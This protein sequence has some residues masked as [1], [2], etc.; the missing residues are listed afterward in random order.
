MPRRFIPQPLREATRGTVEQLLEVPRTVPRTVPR[1]VSLVLVWVGAT[2]LLVSC[3]LI[4]YVATV[5]PARAAVWFFF[6]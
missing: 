4:A 1:A 2:V 5:L 3:P 6:S